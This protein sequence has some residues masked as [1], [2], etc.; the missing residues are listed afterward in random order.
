MHALLIFVFG[1]VAAF[2]T[3]GLWIRF[4][5]RPRKALLS[6]GTLPQLPAP[7]QTTFAGTDFE[8]R[9]ERHGVTIC[10][11][12][13]LGTFLVAGGQL[14]HGRDAAS[15]IQQ[16]LARTGGLDRCCAVANYSCAHCR[17]RVYLVIQIVR[18]HDRLEIRMCFKC[19]SDCG[20][21]EVGSDDRVP[22]R[23]VGV[24]NILE[25][26]DAQ[27]RSEAAKNK[28]E[29][30]RQLRDE[31]EQ[32]RSKLAANELE[33]YRLD[34]ELNPRTDP[35]AYRDQ[36]LLPDPGVPEDKSLQTPK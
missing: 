22:S 27:D 19:C 29:R 23:F 6:G 36:H 25:W 28:T 17:G 1:F 13:T 26:L 31:H 18:S 20:K 15:R 11:A 24:E 35:H 21:L 34:H 7:P 10:D 2:G 16:L 32:L 5:T 8:K 33:I 4:I 9:L 3:I 14:L 30:L 12:D